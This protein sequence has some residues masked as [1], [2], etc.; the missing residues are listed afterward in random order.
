M[1]NYSRALGAVR[2]ALPKIKY[3]ADELMENHTSF[4]I[5]GPARM[6]FFPVNA[7]ELTGLCGLLSEH[8][9]AAL[10]VGN[11]TN[12]LINDCCLDMAVIKTSGLGVTMCNGENEITAGAGVALSQ[13]ADFAHNNRLS[14]LEFAYGIPGSVGGAVSMNAGAYGGEM[15]DVVFSTTVYSADAGI[16]TITGEQHSFSYRGS[17]FSNSSEIVISSALRLRKGNKVEIKARM[18][19]LN[20]RRRR[21]QPLDLSSAG[22]TFKR[23]KGGY[24]AALIEQVGLKGFAIG[25]AQVSEKHSGFIVNRGGATF[26]EVVSLIEHVREAVFKQFGIELE[27]EVKIIK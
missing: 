13:L 14:G 9:V 21:S 25:G 18:D 20:A 11:G 27:P 5:G 10:I 6:M 22:S 8:G 19:E 12:L 16:V 3:R 4:R 26:A 15:K 17:R 2:A 23:P 7:A 1:D 24:A